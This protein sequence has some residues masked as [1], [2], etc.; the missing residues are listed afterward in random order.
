MSRKLIVTMTIV[1]CAGLLNAC[2]T[3]TPPPEAH[4][5]AVEENQEAAQVAS[6]EKDYDPNEII[7]K[8]TKSTTSRISRVKDCRTAEQ[9]RRSTSNAHRAVNEMIKRSTQ[10]PE[11]SY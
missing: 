11:R 6:V 3:N 10:L 2:A 8:T 5:D 4:L 1:A 9:W 7:C